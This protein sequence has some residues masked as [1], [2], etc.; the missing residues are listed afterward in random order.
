M[1]LIKLIAA[2]FYVYFIYSYMI[3][4]HATFYSKLSNLK[5]EVV[6]ILPLKVHNK[7]VKRHVLKFE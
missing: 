3:W 5:Q 7:N 2:G 6:D 1:Q 4:M